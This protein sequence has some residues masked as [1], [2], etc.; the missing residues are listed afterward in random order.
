[1]L[2]LAVAVAVAANA[3]GAG[4]TQTPPPTP[5][6]ATT[7]SSDRAFTSDRRTS[8]RDRKETALPAIGGLALG[9]QRGNAFLAISDLTARNGAWT[10]VVRRTA[11]SLGRHGAVV[12][13]PATASHATDAG[14]PV[15]VGDATGI[16]G[17]GFILW[18]LGNGQARVRGDLP[19]TDLLRLAELTTV[20]G[21]RP[22]VR[23]PEGFRVIATAPLRLPMIHEIRYGSDWLGVRVAPG[24][25]L[26][27]AALT[28]GGGFEDALFAAGAAPAGTVHGFPAVVSPV[29]GGNGTLAWEPAP[30]VVAYLGWTGAEMGPKVVTALRGLAENTYVLSPRQWLATGPDLNQQ[31]NS[32]SD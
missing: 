20:V 10:V 16:S 21:G 14:D 17:R 31:E 29:H 28:T 6:A 4:S 12:T 13:Y 3:L 23:P 2:T 15:R 8:P 26:M 25:G 22:Q 19:K 9:G 7:G 27:Y 24:D 30:G 1:M 32:P 18:P 5:S 11:G